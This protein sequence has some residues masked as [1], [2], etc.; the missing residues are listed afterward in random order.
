MPYSKEKMK[1][2][3]ETHREYFRAKNREWLRNNPEYNKS[4]QRKY[5]SDPN[6]L[7]KHY[8]RVAVRNALKRGTLIKP[9]SCSE[10]GKKGKVEADHH[11]YSKRLDVTWLCRDCHVKITIRR[12]EQQCNHY[13]I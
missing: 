1:E 4:R 11:D 9:N 6:N 2:Y 13:E 3:R 12:K 7:Q 5:L 8:A 10:C